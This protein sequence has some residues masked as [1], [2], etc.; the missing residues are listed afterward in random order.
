[1]RI[2]F[3]ISMVKDILIFVWSIKH[4]KSTQKVFLSHFHDLGTPLF[5][6]VLYY[7]S[8]LT[9]RST[10]SIHVDEHELQLL[11]L[12]SVSEQYSYQ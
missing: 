12:R 9:S 8:N 2:F 5:V 3:P 10:E 4:P 1:M 6:Y 11:E 7:L